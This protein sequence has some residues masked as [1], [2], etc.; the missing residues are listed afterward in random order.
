MELLHDA[1]DGEKTVT[2]AS[3]RDDVTGLLFEL[4][5]RPSVTPDDA[6]CQAILGERLERLGFR[7]ESMPF[8]DV[9]NLWARLGDEGPVFCFAGHTDVVPPGAIEQWDSDPFEPEL[10]DG[11]VYGR[12]A[13]DMKASLAAFVVA[14]E[15]FLAGRERIGGSFGRVSSARGSRSP[16]HRDL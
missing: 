5:R 11:I 10:L 3:W 8:N 16:P 1:P 2:G 4:I 13:A 7:L 9:T 12:G 15:R 6:G 14:L